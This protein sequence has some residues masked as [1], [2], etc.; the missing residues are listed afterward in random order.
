MGEGAWTVFSRH[1]RQLPA[2]R[3]PGR[4]TQDD[5]KK[6]GGALCVRRD[7]AMRCPT[8]AP[9]ARSSQAALTK[10]VVKFRADAD[11]WQIHAPAHPRWQAPRQ[12][13]EMHHPGARR[14]YEAARCTCPL[15]HF[16]HS[17]SCICPWRSCPSSYHTGHH[18]PRHRMVL[19]PGGAERYCRF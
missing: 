3:A 13:Q 16:A 19:Q 5:C 17:I 1:G 18:L 4:R 9:S 7:A 12:D 10:Q 14:I 11:S 15:V 2:T 8:Q 6:G